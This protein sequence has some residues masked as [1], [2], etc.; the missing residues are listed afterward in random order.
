G[1]VGVSDVYRQ[2]SLVN[3]QQAS[4]LP[5]Q[6]QARQTKS[7]LAILLGRVPQGYQ[8]AAEP[9][10]ALSRLAIN[11]GLPSELLQ[12]RPDVAAAEMRLQA[13]TANVAAARAAL[14]PSIQLSGSG[15]LASQALLSLTDP[16]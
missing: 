9:L 14:L 5:L 4:L 6:E 16:S 7:A 12:R 8:L 3:S 1:A 10:A 11:A 13:A 15:G 2:R